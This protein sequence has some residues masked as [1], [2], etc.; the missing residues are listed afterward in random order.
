MLASAYKMGSGFGMRAMGGFHMELGIELIALV[1]GVWLLCWLKSA[2]IGKAT[3]AK[4]LGYLAVGLSVLMLICTLYRGVRACYMG[5]M[6]NG[7]AGDSCPME[8]DKM[9]MGNRMGMQNMPE[10]HPQLPSGHPLIP[11]AP[12][13]K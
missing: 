3:L 13:T 5:C 2:N 10:G 6:M 7:K 1:L 9:G 12:E 4:W 8:N 11:P